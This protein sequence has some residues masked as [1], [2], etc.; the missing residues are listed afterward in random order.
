[1]NSTV[2]QHCGWLHFRNL[3][4]L[5]LI[6]SRLNTSK[7][8]LPAIS[9]LLFNVLSI[10][11]E[12]LPASLCKCTARQL[13]EYELSVPTTR[14]TCHSAFT[15]HFVSAWLSVFLSSHTPASQHDFM[16]LLLYP[17]STASPH[18][19]SLTSQGKCTATKIQGTKNHLTENAADS[20]NWQ[21]LLSH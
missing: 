10:A 12:I 5:S 6:E 3:K 2:N 20:D 17:G 16:D 11:T 13:A 14:M 8:D 1:M 18:R 15:G 7:C 21:H 9:V 19:D 4:G